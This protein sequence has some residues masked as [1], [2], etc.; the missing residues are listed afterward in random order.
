VIDSPLADSPAFPYIP[1]N[2]GALVSTP[3]AHRR[4]QR[5][6]RPFFCAFT[7]ARK[8]RFNML[9]KIKEKSE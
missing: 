6:A 1:F 3:S 7:K 9:Q 5:A 4:F 2:S 8:S